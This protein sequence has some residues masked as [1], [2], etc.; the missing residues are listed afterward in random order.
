[1]NTYTK[2]TQKAID[3][4]INKSK[5][6]INTGEMVVRYNGDVVG[7]VD[8]LQLVDGRIEVKFNISDTSG[9]IERYMK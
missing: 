3:D 7:S 5:E 9:R 6:L 2:F 4:I 1:M 8:E